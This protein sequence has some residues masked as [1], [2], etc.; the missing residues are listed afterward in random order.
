MKRSVD[1]EILQYEESS[2]MLEASILAAHNKFFKYNLNEQ[3]RI[4]GEDFVLYN[5]VIEYFRGNS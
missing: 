3:S 2:K 1:N 4:D 5:T